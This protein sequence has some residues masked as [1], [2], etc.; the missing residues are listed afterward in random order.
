M[1]QI[2][3]K[4]PQDSLLIHEENL[5]NQIQMVSDFVSINVVY[6]KH[7]RKQI[8]L[9][10]FIVSVNVEMHVVI[11][12][13]VDMRLNKVVHLD[14]MAAKR[15]EIDWDAKKVSMREITEPFHKGN[16]VMQ[17]PVVVQE[18]KVVLLRKLN[19]VLDKVFELLM[20]KKDHDLADILLVLEP[21]EG[22]RVINTTDLRMNLTRVVVIEVNLTPLLINIGMDA[23]KDGVVN[24]HSI[25][26]HVHSDCREKV[27]VVSTVILVN[28]ETTIVHFQDY[29]KISMHEAILRNADVAVVGIS[30]SMELVDVHLLLLIS[31]PG[32]NGNEVFNFL[33]VLP[34]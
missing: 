32:K 6:Y 15:I 18:D 23:V 31:E 12:E 17:L 1:Q 26:L 16:A 30:V 13:N 21:T 5:T 27:M 7:Y 3:D 29:N 10:N 24:D 2:G 11:D 14:I 34:L 25:P 28:T 22:S 8:Y 9:I 4:K 19:W 33:V 20:V